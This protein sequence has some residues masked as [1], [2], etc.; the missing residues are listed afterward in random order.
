M[1]LSTDSLID[2][3]VFAVACIVSPILSCAC[4]A[5]GL[6]LMPGSI[7]AQVFL[8]ESMTLLFSPFIFFCT[9]LAWVFDTLG[10]YESK[11]N[12][13]DV[14]AATLW[15]LVTCGTPYLYLRRQLRREN[16]LESRQS[17]DR[18]PGRTD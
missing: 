17:E 14:L 12:L 5:M 16:A 1:Q 11:T 10:V 2:I 7:R 15:V 8:Y 6:W 9:L 18:K 3:G 13:W 4:A